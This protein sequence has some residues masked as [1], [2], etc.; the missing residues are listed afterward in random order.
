MVL[1][2]LGEHI[3]AVRKERGLSQEALARRA[4]LS[5][6]VV[7]RIELGIITNPHYLTLD[8]IARALDITV[9]ELVE[10]PEVST[11]GKA[12][13]PPE[14]RPE[15]LRVTV[16]Q[17]R[18]LGFEANQSQVN[19]LN[20]MLAYRANPT[21]EIH[22]FGYVKKKDEPVDF[23]QVEHMLMP[24][25]LLATGAISEDDMRAARGVLAEIKELAGV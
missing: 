20:Q 17:L 12:S 22:A 9:E 21:G 7:A 24:A 19:V 5:L 16:E 6:N 3:R 15:E 10:E 2:N 13:A 1:E 11:T 8:S 18:E 23:G 4:D 25:Y 14:G